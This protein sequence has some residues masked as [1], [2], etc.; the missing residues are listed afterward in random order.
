MAMYFECW[1]A[2]LALGKQSILLPAKNC[3]Q[4][5]PLS[6]WMNRR[7]E[8]TIRPSW[9]SVLPTASPG[10]HCVT[11]VHLRINVLLN[12]A[13]EVELY[14][15]KS[16]KLKKRTRYFNYLLFNHNGEVWL[17]KRT[18]KDIW[19][20]LYEFP[21]LELD[22]P[23]SSQEQIVESALWQEI[24]D[25]GTARITQISKP[26][27]QTLT[28]QIIHATFWEIELLNASKT[29]PGKYFREKRKNLRKFAFPKIV[30]WYLQDNSLYLNLF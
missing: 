15:V 23:V 28:H 12:L 17:G 1:P 22:Q 26:F 9:T 29:G 2:S 30:D 5:W 25:S 16:R 11:V 6:C 10:V 20:N 7:L 18:G 3:S 27:K 14:P 13:Q 24:A 4:N 19:Q 8:N 21:L